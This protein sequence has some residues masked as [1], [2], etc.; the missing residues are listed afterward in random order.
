MPRPVVQR[1][2]GRP[3]RDPVDTLR[4]RVW[5]H[6]VKQH[7][8]LPSPYAIETTLEPDRFRNLADGIR[9]S[10][11]WDG[12]AKGT[13]VPRRLPGRKYAVELAEVA[14]PGTATY[15]GSPVWRV[16]K[17]E[18]RDTGEVNDLIGGL[19]AAVRDILVQEVVRWDRPERVF[20][21]FDEDAVARL[22]AIGSFE[23]LGAALL[24]VTKSELIGF[25]PLREAALDCYFRMQPA[26]A[27]LP[28]LEPFA[29]ELFLLVDTTCKHWI[30]PTTQSRLEAVIF[31]REVR[32]RHGDTDE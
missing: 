25:P 30:F 14:Y 5:F 9:R 10:S 21:D 7:S 13:R 22:A 2:R 6:A 18:L 4:T 1:G 24:L 28:E 17:R 12:Y 20:V 27:A 32:R 26:L 15:F 19:N 8:G 31:S 16:L 11:T 3:R 23:A 29:E